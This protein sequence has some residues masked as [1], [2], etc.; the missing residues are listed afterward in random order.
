M[1]FARAL[2]EERGRRLEDMFI[3]HGVLSREELNVK[4]SQDYLLS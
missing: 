4:V 1:S 2:A 3:G